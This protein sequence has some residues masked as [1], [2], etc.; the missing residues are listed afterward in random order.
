MI[1]N[2]SNTQS[3]PF[4]NT[5]FLSDSD[6]A[7][8]NEKATGLQKIIETVF[9]LNP[10]LET[11]GWLMKRF[12]EAK[13]GKY[14]NINSTR[15]CLSNLSKEKKLHKTGKT[16]I[17]EESKPECFY[18]RQQPENENKPLP[19]EPIHETVKKFIEIKNYSQQELF[20]G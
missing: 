7:I 11:T 15:R 1:D 6:W 18:S 9:D 16:R 12:L 2:F 5:V 4:Y 13:M 14:V 19:G 17:G 3:Q 10:K 20:G 8:E